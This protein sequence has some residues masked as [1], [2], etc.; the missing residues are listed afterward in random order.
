MCAF[1]ENRHIR[2]GEEFDL[3]IKCF[4][5]IPVSGCMYCRPSLLL[6]VVSGMCFGQYKKQPL[7]SWNFVS[8]VSLLNVNSF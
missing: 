6:H 8:F 4:I 1:G 7:I 2:D 5:F 3:E